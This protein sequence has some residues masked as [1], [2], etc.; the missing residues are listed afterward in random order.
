MRRG[1]GPGAA[2]GFVCIG[3]APGLGWVT[4]ESEE[5][6]SSSGSSGTAGQSVAC[7][8]A[9]LRSVSARPIPWRSHHL[10]CFPSLLPGRNPRQK[11]AADKEANGRPSAGTAANEMV[12]SSL[13]RKARNKTHLRSRKMLLA[14]GKMTSRFNTAVILPGPCLFCIGCLA[15]IS[16]CS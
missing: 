2:A 7:L 11:E 6:P 9:L 3:P 13:Q 16:P 5:K 14:G 12:E 1:C 10:L 4:R 15:C 8:A